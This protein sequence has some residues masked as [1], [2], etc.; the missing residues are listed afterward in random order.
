M[1]G[2]VANRAREEKEKQELQLKQE[3]KEMELKRGE[4]LKERRKAGLETALQVVEIVEA[5]PM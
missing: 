5:L 1:E 3:E 2:D 4:E